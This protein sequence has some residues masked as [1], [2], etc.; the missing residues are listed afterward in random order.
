M[1]VLS[2]FEGLDGRSDKTHFKLREMDLTAA[3]HKTI[4]R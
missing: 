4:R 1:K 2:L 3:R